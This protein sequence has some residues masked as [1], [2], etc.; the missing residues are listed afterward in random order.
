MYKFNVCNYVYCTDLKGY[1]LICIRRVVVVFML[2]VLQ[3][4]FIDM[5]DVHETKVGTSNNEVDVY[6]RQG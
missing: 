1:C 5:A 6:K 3:K 4:N 2:R